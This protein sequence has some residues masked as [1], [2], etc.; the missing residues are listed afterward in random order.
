[1]AALQPMPHLFFNQTSLVAQPREQVLQP[2]PPQLCAVTCG[3]QY[4]F[5][6][7]RLLL[8]FWNNDEDELLCNCNMVLSVTGGKLG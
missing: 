1:M 7:V 8:A 6:V 5:A 2:S 4:T 3:Q